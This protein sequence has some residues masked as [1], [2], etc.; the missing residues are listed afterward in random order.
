MAVTKA[1][2]SSIT[3]FAKYNRT[4]AAQKPSP[5]QWVISS[6]TPHTSLDGTT[7]TA[8]TNGLSGVIGID[9]DNNYRIIT[10]NS[11]ATSSNGSSW[12]KV[13]GT[14]ANQNAFQT[15]GSSITKWVNNFPMGVVNAAAW[16]WLKN[17]YSLD[18]TRCWDVTGYGPTDFLCW[19]WY[20]GSGFAL[21]SIANYNSSN[22]STS[23]TGDIFPNQAF[24]L[25]YG[26]G[27]WLGIFNN[28]IWRTS[29]ASGLSGWTDTGNRSSWGFPYIKFVNGF[30]YYFG[31]GD[32]SLLRS[33]NGISWTSC[34]PNLSGDVVVDIEFAGGVWVVISSSKISS[35]TD[36]INFTQRVSGTSGL[37]RIM[38]G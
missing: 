9:S 12:T 1:S 13:T 35:G 17:P 16:T 30:F 29:T 15:N 7:W 8:R 5:S 24:G 37:T 32:S 38:Y 22:I 14:G 21:K 18:V 34:T 28:Q 2:A 20:S 36:G 25:Q 3:T 11:T 33:T 4:L 10:G 27:I 26:N 23:N 19:Q 31:N 6:T